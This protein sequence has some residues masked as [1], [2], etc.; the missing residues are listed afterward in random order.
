MYRDEF[1]TCGGIPLKEVRQEMYTMLYYAML[2][3]DSSR[4]TI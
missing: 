4:Y 3:D 2:E 1:V